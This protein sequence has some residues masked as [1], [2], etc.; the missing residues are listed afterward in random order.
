MP[1]VHS[2]R[3]V[4]PR[5]LQV[6]TSLPSHESAHSLAVALQGAGVPCAIYQFPEFQGN[7]WAV[8]VD[9]KSQLGKAT[10]LERAYA[11][12]VVAGRAR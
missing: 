1:I 2:N 9:R 12:G 11:A 8:C 3:A 4:D 10:M 6:G 5:D 7:W